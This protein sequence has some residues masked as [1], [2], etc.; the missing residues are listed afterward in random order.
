M[1]LL[2][3]SPSLPGCF[4]RMKEVEGPMVREMQLLSVKQFRV[5][6]LVTNMLKG[7]TLHSLQIILDFLSYLAVLRCK[8]R[9]WHVASSLYPKFKK[10]GKKGHP[11]YSL[12][13]G[14]KCHPLLITTKDAIVAKTFSFPLYIFNG[15]TN[16]CE[17]AHNKAYFAVFFLGQETGLENT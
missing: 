13:P 16:Q 4:E 1:C 7:R 14:G 6:G 15:S 12:S 3:K 9:Q 11:S 17:K 2:V 5:W 10:K 8:R